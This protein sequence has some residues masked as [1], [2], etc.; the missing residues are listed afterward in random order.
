MLRTAL[1]VAFFVLLAACS[2]GKD[3]FRV[4]QVCFANGQD[5]LRFVQEMKDI[6]DEE[7]MEFIDGSAAAAYG[8]KAGGYDRGRAS[9]GPTI[10]LAVQ[11]DDG[12]MVMAGNMGLAGYQVAL[13]FIEGSSPSEAIRFADKVIGRLGQLWHVKLLPAGSWV[14]LDSKCG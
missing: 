13:W 12:M 11:R 5:A 6:A 14:Q 8:L 3:S 4:A 9:G 7:R 10:H 1:L 2:S